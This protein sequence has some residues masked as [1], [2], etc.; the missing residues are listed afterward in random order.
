[1]DSEK[2]PL[3]GQLGVAEGAQSI[4]PKKLALRLDGWIV[5]GGV[6]LLHAGH[7]RA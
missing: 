6:A 5:S 1:M 3:T 2:L 7:R 4:S